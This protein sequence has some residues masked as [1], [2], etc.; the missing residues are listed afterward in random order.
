MRFL[1]LVLVRTCLCV[2]LEVK[3]ACGHF[4]GKRQ[5]ITARDYVFKVTV[6]RDKYFFSLSFFL[7]LFP[8]IINFLFAFLKLLSNFENAY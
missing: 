1:M 4:Y 8:S 6:S 5:E 2:F 7:C 3:L